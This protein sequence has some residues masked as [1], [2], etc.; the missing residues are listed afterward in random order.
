[1]VEAGYKC[2][3]S[4]C[5]VGPTMLEYNHIDGNPENNHPDNILVVCSNHHSACTSGKIDQRACKLLKE[6]L[7]KNVISVNPNLSS[8]H[9]RQIFREEINSLVSVKKP[10]TKMSSRSI[11]SR[12][13]IL[14][15]LQFPT[16]SLPDSYMSI[17]LL[18]ELKF[19]GSTKA[20]ITSVEELKKHFGEKNKEKFFPYYR[21]AIRSLAKIG[22]KVGLNWIADQHEKQHKNPLIQFIIFWELQMFKKAK[23]YIQFKIIEQKTNHK[24]H[25]ETKYRIRNNMYKL[26][27]EKKS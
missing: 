12:R 17:K 4:T 22:S 9:I 27:I 16:L 20:I 19:S 7:R 10:K 13:S 2:S 23:E 24:N 6:T 25:T 1:M 8:D 26:I 21:E 3:I 5:P 14:S 15:H 18:G 11:L